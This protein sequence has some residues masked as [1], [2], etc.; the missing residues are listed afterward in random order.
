MTAYLCHPRLQCL[1]Y[2]SCEH[3]EWKTSLARKYLAKAI[4]Y[5]RI[6]DP[7]GLTHYWNWGYDQ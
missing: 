7:K 6:A 5:M 2:H 1:D 3:P 4:R